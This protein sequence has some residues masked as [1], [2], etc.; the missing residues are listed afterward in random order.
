MPLVMQ[1]T[2]IKDTVNKVGESVL[3]YGFVDSKRD[4][5][6]V[7][8]IDL[9]DVTGKIQIV[10]Y[11]MLGEVRQE[12]ILKIVGEVKARPEKQ[13]NPD[14]ETG[15]VE[16]DVKEYEVLAMAGDLPILVEGDGLEMNEEVRLKYRYLDLRR[17]RLAHNM[18]LRSDFVQALRTALYEE[19]FMEVETPI[20]SKATKEGARDFLVPSRL[21]PG[22]FYALP[23]SPQQYKQLLMTAGVERYFQVARC[24]RDED[25]RADRLLELTQLDL[26]MSYVFEPSEVMAVTEKVVKAAVKAVGGQLVNEE[27][28]VIDYQEAM[29]KYGADRFDMRTDEEKAAGKLAFAWVVNFPFFKKVDKSDAAEVIDGKSGWTFTHNPFSAAM[30]ADQADWL[31][32]KN[33]EKLHAAQY[34]LVC[35]GYEVG[36][37]SL[38]AHTREMLLATYKIMGYSEAEVEASVGHMLTAFDIGT[39]P[40][41]GLALGLDRLLMVLTGE[42]SIKEVV[43]FP[44]TGS[45]KTAVMEAPAKVTDKQLKEL[46][47]EIEED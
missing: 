15:T 47:L 8:F 41:G 21:Q 11:K 22:E 36:G 9:R 4:H 34:D 2:L 12:S 20:L 43:A 42:E 46:N 37:G 40:H 7:T 19:N 33:I 31:A 17:A 5:G 13:V 23:Q 39:P 44:T 25:L 3:L 14:L 10:G 6:K 29:E 18:K 1:R 16:L 28:P 30:P 26:E 27:F 45:G 24:F 32:G 38:R 35:D